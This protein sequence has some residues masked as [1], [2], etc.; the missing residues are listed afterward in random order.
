MTEL[1]DRFKEVKEAI[2]DALMAV[3]GLLEHVE[4]NISDSREAVRNCHAYEY[5]RDAESALDGL[6]FVLTDTL[7]DDGL[8]PP[9][10]QTVPPVST[11]VNCDTSDEEGE[12]EV[13]EK[14]LVCA[15]PPPIPLVRQETVS[16]GIYIERLGSPCLI[17]AS[18]Y[19][20]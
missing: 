7:S 12:E 11:P 1:E 16:D 8:S 3:D 6:L 14:D 19:R 17:P 2:Y 5:L 15:I 4:E 9:I 20:G 18:G 13:D 10:P